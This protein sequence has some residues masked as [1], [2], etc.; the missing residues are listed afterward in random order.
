MPPALQTDG[1]R[2]SQAT[3][4]AVSAHAIV[5]LCAIIL[6]LCALFLAGACTPTATSVTV[7]PTGMVTSP[8]ARRAEPSPLE[9]PAATLS[10]APV[11]TAAPAPTLDPDQVA[12]ITETIENEL[13]SREIDPLCLRWEDADDDGAPEWVGLYLR[14]ADPPRLEGFVLDGDVWHELHAPQEDESG[15]GTYPTCELDVRDVNADGRTEL[16]IRGRTVGDVDLLHIFVWREARYNLLASFAGNAGIEVANIDG[17]ME[18]E[19]I[20]RW[21]AGD[22]LAWEQVHTWDGA[23]Y[24]WT[25]ERYSWLYADY[26]HAY[27][28]DTPEHVTI[29]FYLALADRNL[30]GAHRMLSSA[31]ESSQAYD[32]WAA[33]FNTMLSAEVG[34]IHEIER[35]DDA[36]TVS[37]QVRSYDNLDGYIIGR[38][39][40]VTWKVVRE[41]EAWQLQQGNNELL[42]R[43]EAAYLP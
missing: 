21:D 33:G 15:L 22:G 23:H 14:P 20:A 34:S 31:A 7:S 25:W 8:T 30:P 11:S 36:A 35:V 3:M 5:R 19:I 42:D 2:R 18:K 9:T 41:E 37:A 24:G 27:L 16:L 29:S 17:S 26:P 10:R 13:A 28:T 39:W 40:D 1:R 6:A 43:W 38:L 12:D 32:A 4:K